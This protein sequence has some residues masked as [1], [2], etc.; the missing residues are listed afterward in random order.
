MA[1][2]GLLLQESEKR[3][4]ENFPQIMMICYLNGFNEAKQKLIEAKGVLKVLENQEAYIA[5]KEAMRVLRKMKY[6]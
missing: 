5:F 3:D 6:N 2:K 1:Q 4:I